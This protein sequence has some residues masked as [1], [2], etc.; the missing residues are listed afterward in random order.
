MS[1]IDGYRS[2]QR[3]VLVPRRSHPASDSFTS[4]QG[5]GFGHGT[6]QTV[7]LEPSRHLEASESAAARRAREAEPEGAMAAVPAGR[8]PLEGGGQ[9]GGG[10]PAVLGREFRAARRIPGDRTKRGKK[11]K[12]RRRPR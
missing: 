5:R 12:E 1:K 6:G 3:H 4:F 11:K 8:R 10:V 9:L 2:T 7:Q